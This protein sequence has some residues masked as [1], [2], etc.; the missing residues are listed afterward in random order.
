MEGVI[1]SISLKENREGIPNNLTGR[2][3]GGKG[4]AVG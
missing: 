1:P 2:R 4:H 3:K